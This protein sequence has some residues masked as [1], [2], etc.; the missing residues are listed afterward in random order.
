[1]HVRSLDVVGYTLTV[2]LSDGTTVRANLLPM[3]EL[4]QRERKP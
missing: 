2:T 1:V 3:L 4:Y